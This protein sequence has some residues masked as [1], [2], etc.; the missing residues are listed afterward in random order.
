M[1]LSEVT[2]E[3]GMS[4]NVWVII[5][6]NAQHVISTKTGKI[7]DYE[8]ET[9]Y[10][11]M[12]E[13]KIALPIEGIPVSAEGK[14]SA[15]FKARLKT[16]WE[17]HHEAT[18]EW[19]GFVV[20]GE[21]EVAANSRNK[22]ALKGNELPYYISIRAMGGR[23]V[24]NA[25]ARRDA[26]ITL[27]ENGHILDPVPTRVA[28]SAKAKVYLRQ[29]KKDGGFVGDPQTSNTNWDAGTCL[30][31]AGAHHFET[32]KGALEAGSA[33]RIVSDSKTLVDGAYKHMYSSDIGWIYYD[34]K[35]K[36]GSRDG[37]KQ[38][39]K[40][41]KT[42]HAHNSS[43]D[44]LHYGDRVKI[45]NINWPKANLGIKG[46]WLQC[47]NDDPTVWILKKEAKG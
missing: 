45:Y 47:V 1:S 23:I 33:V 22:W 11:M 37:K 40:L 18:F 46:K 36:T 14:E 31:T 9:Y 15:E 3:N 28:I 10:K 16:H 5:A 13:G 17:D 34:K 35:R 42:G 27:D 38:M 21:L 2:V 20:P 26:V 25:V 32:D 8:F 6:E 29:D 4:D 19:S 41:A 24:A 30:K 39:W 12:V 7:R 44:T 43:G